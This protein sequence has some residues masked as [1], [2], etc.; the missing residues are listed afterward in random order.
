M[1]T[2]R[3]WLRNG[4]EMLVVGGANSA[5]QGAMLFSR[6]ASQVTMLVRDE[7]GLRLTMGSEPS[8]GNRAIRGGKWPLFWMVR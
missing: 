7:S 1:V 8:S 4:L 5:G 6:Y 3:S 2:E